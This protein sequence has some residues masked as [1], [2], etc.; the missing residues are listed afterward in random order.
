[1]IAGYDLAE[2]AIEPNELMAFQRGK[3]ARSFVGG[4][5]EGD[6]RLAVSDLE[7]DPDGRY[8]VE[9]YFCHNDTRRYMLAG[10]V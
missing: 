6:A 3:V 2:M 9:E 7:R 1:M 10:L 5:D 4:S 8:R